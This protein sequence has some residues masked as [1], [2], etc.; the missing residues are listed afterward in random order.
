MDGDAPTIIQ[1]KVIKIDS[2]NNLYNLFIPLNRKDIITHNIPVWRPDIDITWL[3]PVLVKISFVPQSNFQ[4]L[5][6]V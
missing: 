4:L 5:L 2:I 6:I 3:V 1:Y